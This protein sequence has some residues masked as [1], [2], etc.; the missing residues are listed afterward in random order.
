[1][2]FNKL[3]KACEEEVSGQKMEG[4]RVLFIYDKIEIVPTRHSSKNVE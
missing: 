4:A 2:P 1:M 3:E